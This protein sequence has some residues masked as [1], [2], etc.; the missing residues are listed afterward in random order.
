VNPSFIKT[1]DGETTAGCYQQARKTRKAEIWLSSELFEPSLNI[2]RF[3]Y[4]ILGKDRLF[5]T[6]FHELGHHKSTLIHSVDK[7]E[8]EAYAERYM[9]AYKKCWN[10]RYG[11]SKVFVNPFRLLFRSLLY[12]L[13]G[14]FWLFRK[15]S[16]HANLFYR[17]LRGEISGGAFNKQFYRLMGLDR[18]DPTKG[19]K[20]WI[21]PLNRKKYRER[22]HIP[23]R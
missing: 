16:A 1:P 7:F 17:N 8:A 9:L 3:V 19:K 12:I 4:R 5:E 13:R 21:H 14:I 11:P 15:R 18:D 2:E 10:K 22:F 23:D 20:K 6:L